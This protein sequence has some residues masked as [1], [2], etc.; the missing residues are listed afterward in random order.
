MVSNGGRPGC[1]VSSAGSFV[2]RTSTDPVALI[3]A[4][5]ARMH[6]LDPE[7]ATKFT[8]MNAMLAS[9]IST[10]RFRTFLAG[11]FAGL[12]VLLA[13][14]GV[15]GVMTYATAQR[16]AELGL[17]MALGAGRSGI[18]GMILGRAAVLAAVGLA[19]GA[20][21]SLALGR[22]ASSMLFGIEPSDALTYIAAASALCVATIGAAAIPAWRATR[23]DPLTALREE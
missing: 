13:M 12:A 6:R 22:V 11:A 17:R 14:A 20:V 18:L 15:Y 1:A 4:V 10:P 2:M 9:S 3:P 8:T 7:I 16:T 5:R 19:L 21:L 23:I